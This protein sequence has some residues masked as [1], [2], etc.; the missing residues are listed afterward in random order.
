MKIA[1][2]KGKGSVGNAL[3]R[4]WKRSIYSHCEL[5]IDGV[6]YS[7]S[8]M[9]HGVRGKIINLKPEHWDLIDLP[10]ADE[11]AALAHFARTNGQPYSW[12]SI[13]WAQFF[14]REY[15]EARASFCSEW[16]A[17]ALG[18]PTPAIHSPESL[19]KLCEYLGARNA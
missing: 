1:L 12:A 11:A 7:S 4:W 18:L 16:C 6:C 5:L 9:D 17:A 2:Y 3:V 13:V 14:G 19:G 10:L 15:D 8:V